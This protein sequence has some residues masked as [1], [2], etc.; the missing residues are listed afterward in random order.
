[1]SAKLPSKD[2]RDLA[3]VSA[4]KDIAATQLAAEAITKT[5]LE[6]A[7]AIAKGC[8]ATAIFV[9]VDALAHAHLRFPKELAPKVFYV[10]RSAEEEAGERWRGGKFLRVPHVP[11]TRMGQMKLALFM[12]MSRNFIRPGDIVVFLGGIAES[13]TLD[14]I[15]ITQV[16]REFE[17]YSATEQGDEL[18]PGVLP[19]VLERVISIAAE[20]GLEGREGKPVGTIFVVGDSKR[21]LAL[22]RPLTLNPF[23]GYPEEQRNILNPDLEET[24]KEFAAIDGAFVIRG[25]GVIE[26]CGV[27]LKTASQKEY[28]L[29]PG[30]GTRHHAAAAITAVT[31]AI[32][33]TVSQSTGTVTVFRH[34]KPV[35]EIEKP[36]ST[37]REHEEFVLRSTGSI[38]RS[39]PE[40]H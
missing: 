27:Y 34:G 31:D 24:V 20:L 25:D 26:S 23:Q 36:R 9:Y 33:V 4:R 13:G 35:T 39:E 3:R 32:A 18:P 28:E 30:L 12:A 1:M 10:T 8:Q 5:L 14:T 16:G 40:R 37:A 29:P 6:H 21:V 19:E 15:L 7:P 22:S 11:L 2:K 17:I 38:P